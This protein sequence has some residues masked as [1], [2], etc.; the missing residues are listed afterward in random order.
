MKI[1]AECV[2]CLIKRCSY[3]AGLVNPDKIE[4]VVKLATEMLED[5]YS[6]EECSASVATEVHH[7]VYTLLGGDPY[8]DIKK[9]CNQVAMSLVPRAEKLI[10]SDPDPLKAAITCAIVGNIFDFGIAGSAQDP[11]ELG[12]TFDELY[13]EGIHIDDTEKIKKYLMEGAKVLFFTD[14]CGEVVFDKLLCSELKK[15]GVHL[16]VVV[17]GEPILT[18]ATRTDAE[19]LVF[20][21]VADEIMDTNAFAVGLDF[22]KIT[23]ELLEKIETADI[24]ISKGMANFESFSE[25]NYKPIAYL[26]RTK[27]RPVADALGLGTELNIAKLIE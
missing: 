8:A 23:P 3:E 10:S 20:S 21:E 26:M 2:P 6:P 12:R 4:E 14:N 16:T 7:A 9:S 27:C 1:V 15:S 22:D 19:D 13:S 17:K 5:L 24:I 25:R 18:D 11:E